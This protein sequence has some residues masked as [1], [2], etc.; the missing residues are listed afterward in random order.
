MSSDCDG[1]EE[2]GTFTDLNDQ[3][4]SAG[5][6][7]P[8]LMQTQPLLLSTLIRH[9]ARHHANAEVVSQ[10]SEHVR[11]RT[12]YAEVERRSRRLA[13]ALQQLGVGMGNRVA[14]LAWN[15]YRHLELYYAISGIGAICH[16]VNP[17]L[18]LDDVIY[19]MQ[20]AGDGVVFADLSFVQLVETV[21]PQI[22]SLK[23]VVML[24]DSAE[25]PDVR[26]P[27]GVAFYCYEDLLRAV[28]DDFAWPTFDENTASA[29]C[30]TSG[31]TG[32]PK[33][34]L[35]SH[36][37]AMLHA[38]AA[39]GADVFGFRA[40]DRV[41]PGASMY[42]ATAWG[43]PYCTAMVGAALV[44]PGRHL[45]GPSLTRML[46][47]E[48]V[49]FTVGVPTIW[50]GVL[51]HM[52]STG[53]RFTALKRMLVAGSACPRLLIEGFAPYGVEVHQ[54]WGM[55]ET[56]P[57]VT[58]HA[59][60]P[61]TSELAQEASVGLRLRQGRTVCGVDIKIVDGEGNELPWDG[62][63]FGDLLCR[64]PWIAR[65]YLNLGSEGA[66]GANGW[67][68]T[69]DV[70]TIDPEGYV[71]LVDRSKDVIKSGGEWISSIAL[72]NI[73]VAHPDVAEAAIIAARHEKWMERPVLLVVPREGRTIDK[74][75]LLKLY[76]GAVARWW[77]PDDVIVVPELP[78]TATGKLNKLALRQQYGD[79]LVGSP[80]E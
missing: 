40:V 52:R 44:L 31:T 1:Q 12:T 77:L 33:G 3:S 46:N 74:A 38:Y 54:A 41:L 35:Y 17:R 56:S 62:V 13:K 64:G 75:E 69:G 11:H 72:E 10:M 55:T 68:A 57:L 78:H 66:A 5:G 21:A 79:H 59:A 24:A 67:F 27:R 4:F 37:S 48:R 15:N 61:A 6:A 32:R 19:I 30:Y 20:H 14:T 71:H 47:E 53:T 45:D 16:T 80:Q 43:I 63:A 58:Y 76:D 73:A 39:N 60:K 28:D 23:A 8:G 29:L 22:P 26:L 42:H 34:V 18:A 36:R 51:D 65:E 2:R 50:L 7:M 9:A 70:A 25:M 49:T